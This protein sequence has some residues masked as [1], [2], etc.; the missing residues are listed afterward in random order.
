M[1]VNH[2]EAVLLRD[3]S[4]GV[5]TETKTRKIQNGDS[6]RVTLN[7]DWVDQ[8]NLSSEGMQTVHSVSMGIKPVIVQH[9]AIIVQPASV[10]SEVN[11]D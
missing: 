3:D 11:H 5:S 1:P 7:A 6:F 2:A 8:L 10:L 4:I 9:P